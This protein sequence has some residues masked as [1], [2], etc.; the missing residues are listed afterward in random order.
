MIHPVM[1]FEVLG[2]DGGKLRKFYGD[3]FGWTFDVIKRI[4]YGVAKTG[5][6]RGILGGVGPSSPVLRP[7]WAHT[8]KNGR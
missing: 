7:A 5:H 6:R 2:A 3:L 1:W 8:I 4:D